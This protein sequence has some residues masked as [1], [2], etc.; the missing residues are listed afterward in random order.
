MVSAGYTGTMA[1]H[2]GRPG[3]LDFAV[4]FQYILSDLKDHDKK[5]EAFPCSIVVLFTSF[6]LLYFKFN[7]SLEF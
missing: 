1:A 3:T 5:Q 6:I 2:T 7:Y 4:N